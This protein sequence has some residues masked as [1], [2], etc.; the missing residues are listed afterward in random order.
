MEDGVKTRRSHR[1]LSKILELESN[2][3]RHEGSLEDPS[4][5]EVL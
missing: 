4:L 3:K 5:D 1:S 2:C